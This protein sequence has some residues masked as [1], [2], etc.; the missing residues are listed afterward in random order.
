M[1]LF[2]R[3]DAAPQSFVALCLLSIILILFVDGTRFDAFVR[4]HVEMIVHPL[5]VFTRFSEKALDYTR[6]HIHSVDYLVKENKRLKRELLSMGLLQA[7]NRQLSL[8]NEEYAEL[9]KITSEHN[10]DTVFARAF[11]RSQK[12]GNFRLFVNKGYEEGLSV[13]DVAFDAK[14]ILGQIIS[15]R[16]H[17]AEVMLLTDAQHALPVIVG[18]QH[19]N[20]ILGGIGRTDILR[21]TTVLPQH[22]VKLGDK[23]YTSGMAKRFPRG[24][25]I[26]DVA[27]ISDESYDR[28]I[29]IDVKP[30]SNFNVIGYMLIQTHTKPR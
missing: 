11:T 10:E 24:Y 23:V 20:F 6:G 2:T 1:R 27:A 22:E 29:Y 25:Y 13:G 17:M 5:F 14:G 28:Q 15:V 18:E 8:V 26:G 30:R 3:S 19:H 7:R 12:L 16:A 21:I 9:L 4:R